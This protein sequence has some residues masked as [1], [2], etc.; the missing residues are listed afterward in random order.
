MVWWLIAGALFIGVSGVATGLR[1]MADSNDADRLAYGL[2]TVCVVGL[3]VAP[4]VLVAVQEVL[5]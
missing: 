5:R 3:L 4:A 1:H 2:V